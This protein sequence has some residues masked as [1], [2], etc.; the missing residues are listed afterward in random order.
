MQTNQ[1]YQENKA[2]VDQHALDIEPALLINPELSTRLGQNDDLLTLIHQTS[3][4]GPLPHPDIITE[5]ERVL[6]GSA[7][8]IFSMAEKEQAFRHITQNNAVT[9]AVT[10]DKRGQWMGFIVTLCVLLIATIFAYLG[11]IIFAAT[12]IG[13]DLLGL[14][15]VFVLGRQLVRSE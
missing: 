1:P 5:Y 12:L 9:G 13:V 11:E 7:E 2:V 4:S 10:R 6:S 14:T 3:F 8:R 15:T